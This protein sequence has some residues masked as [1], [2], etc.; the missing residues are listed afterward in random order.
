MQSK[1]H[2]IYT[3]GN[4]E[5]HSEKRT[6]TDFVKEKAG[7]GLVLPIWKNLNLIER[8]NGRLRLQFLPSNVLQNITTGH[9]S[10]LGEWQGNSI[11]ATEVIEE[12]ELTEFISEY[13]EFAD[14]RTI[15]KQLDNEAASI[16]AFARGIIY[17][18]QTHQY[19]HRCGTFSQSI[20]AGHARKCSNSECGHI[21][22]PRI[23]PAVIVLIEHR[24]KNG[25]P[26]C[27]LGKA[28]HYP[29]KMRSTLA[30]F[31]EIG[32]SLEE[33]VVREMKEESGLEVENVRY[34]ASQ[35]WPFPSSLMVGFFA[36]SKT[37][38]LQLAPNE[39]SDAQWYT[40]D[41]IKE[42]VS[43]GELILSKE[44]SIARFLIEMWVNATP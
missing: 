11:Q 21:Y 30:G 31:V 13:C 4:I 22:Y 19:C 40:R 23:S 26:I 33:A 24:P 25:E 36:E 29:D 37:T 12:K 42:L 38:Q 35:P 28:G 20:E 6:D 9:S 27:L 1:K 39:V 14:I 7:S 32:E 15:S 2:L 43:Q 8:V 5:R 18:H 41:E 17:W 10:Y 44:D 16:G 34:I 3:N